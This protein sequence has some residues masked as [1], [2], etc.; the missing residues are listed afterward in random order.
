MA[1]LGHDAAAQRRVTV[2]VPPN[3]PAIRSSTPPA[4]R[5]VESPAP[6]PTARPTTPSV[7]FVGP[8]RSEPPSALRF[9]PP[10]PPKATPNAVGFNPPPAPKP[11]PTV[12]GPS[13]PPAVKSVAPAVEF[14][15]PPTPQAT[16]APQV[17]RNQSAPP[18]AASRRLPAAAPVP[19]SRSRSESM[20]QHVEQARNRPTATRLQP[21]AKGAPTIRRVTTTDHL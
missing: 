9:S 11:A 1:K 16:A 4:I 21:E 8:V 18:A 12:D 15:S 19:Q 13:P 2:P 3:R 20:F 7:R 6:T 17:G 14:R 10:P 5:T